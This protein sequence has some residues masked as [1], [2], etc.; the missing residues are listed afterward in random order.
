MQNLSFELGMRRTAT[1]LAVIVLT[2]TLV[3]GVTGVLLAFYY[4]P[5]AGRAYTSLQEIVND[6]QNGQLIL[7]L[8]NYA[9]HGLIGVALIEIILMFLG[10]RFTRSWL[11]TWISGIL[12]TLTAIGLGW[13]AMILG[14]D[15][16]GYWRFRIELGT[17]EAIPVIGGTLRD[18]LVGGGSV[19][20]TTVEHLYTI[21][22]YL[23]SAGAVLLA[24]VHLAAS[25]L[26]ARPVA[27]E[28]ASPVQEDAP[29]PTGVGS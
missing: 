2:L 6:V 3:A 18:I 28:Q 20:T 7:G 12:L 27:Q 15:Q 13:T 29:V 21:H 11:T 5:A 10:R 14:W 24:I 26:A 8:H 16:L 22:S 25:I 23:L 9:G 4:E 19:N 1:V 17:I